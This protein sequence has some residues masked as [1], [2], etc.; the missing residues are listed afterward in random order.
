[1]ELV[2]ACRARGFG[3]WPTLSAPVQVRIGILN[4][5]NDAAITDI[6]T[7]FGQAIRDLGGEY[8]EAAVSAALDQHYA[9]VM[10]AE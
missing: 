4:L 5:L 2:Q 6:V 8:D 10:A 3:I 9:Q 7:R 1:M